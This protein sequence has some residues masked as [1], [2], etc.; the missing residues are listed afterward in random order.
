MWWLVL[1]VIVLLSLEG[2][3]GIRFVI[4][5]EECLSHKVELGATVH[6]SFVVIKSEGS[7]HYTAEGVD[8]VVLISFPSSPLKIPFLSF[9]SIWMIFHFFF[10][11]TKFL[12]C[13][14]LDYIF[15]TYFWF[16]WGRRT[17]LGYIF[18]KILDLPCISLCLRI[19]SQSSEIKKL[20]KLPV[21]QFSYFF[22]HLSSQDK[23]KIACS[24]SQI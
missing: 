15:I 3:L 19:S 23:D 16:S 10:L 17:L 22:S 13:F 7:W 18:I 11:R 6:F 4:D 21:E 8:L 2:C 20:L 12:G 9:P 14:S 5:R 1:L 24:G